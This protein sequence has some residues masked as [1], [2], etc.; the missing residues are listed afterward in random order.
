MPYLQP[1][2]AWYYDPGVVDPAVCLA[3][4]YDQV[5]AGAYHRL[6][7][8]CPSNIVWADLPYGRPDTGSADPYRQAADH[9]RRWIRQGV[10]RHVPTAAFYW[11]VHTFRTPDGGIAQRHGLV[12]LVRSEPQGSPAILPHEMTYEEPVYDRIRHLMATGLQA[13][14]IFFVYRLTE[15]TAA[16]EADIRAWARTHPSLLRVETADGEVHEVWSVE[17]PDEVARIRACFAEVPLLIADGHHRYEALRRLSALR[18]DEPAWSYVLGYLASADQAGLLQ[19]SYH[20]VLTFHRS[21]DES[22]LRAGLGR[23]F[24]L[25]AEDRLVDLSGM[26]RWFE[27]AGAG[28]RILMLASSPLRVY[29]W[30]MKPELY[31][32]LTDPYET[33]DVFIVQRFV[34]EEVLQG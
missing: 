9:L 7:A 14:P 30:R 27:R 13:S 8:Q 25:E 4:P 21:M 18:P 24:D 6:M 15:E 23:L 20:R 11:Y 16:L 5:D 12:A 31:E 17:D 26:Q 28:P 1:L 33:L 3:P 10:L 29:L 19:M 2:T 22:A 34:F 32:A